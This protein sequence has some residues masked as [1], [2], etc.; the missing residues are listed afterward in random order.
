M[1]HLYFLSRFFGAKHHLKY[2]FAALCQRQTVSFY[3]IFEQKAQFDRIL[4][5]Q[6][7]KIN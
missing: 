6:Q 3:K 4:T 7:P 1:E 2:F 5:A